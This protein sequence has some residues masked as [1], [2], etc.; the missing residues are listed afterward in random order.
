MQ[1]LLVGVHNLK[2]GVAAESLSVASLPERRTRG[3]RRRKRAAPS[4]SPSRN[5]GL[6][7]WYGI[8]R[9]RERE[10]ERKAWTRRSLLS[11]GTLPLLSL[12]LS[13]A[14]SAHFLP[15]IYLLLTSA[16]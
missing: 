3:V 15:Y 1:S 14:L 6:L 13:L 5:L 11:S 4:P 12:S 7:S 16:P 9:E 10:R 2:L 8:E